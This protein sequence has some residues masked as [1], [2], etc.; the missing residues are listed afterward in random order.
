LT[1]KMPDMRVVY[2]VDG[3]WCPCCGSRLR[4]NPRNTWDRRRSKK[5][6]WYLSAQ[7]WER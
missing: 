6:S 2:Q 5:M 3:L 1:E 7:S 4:S